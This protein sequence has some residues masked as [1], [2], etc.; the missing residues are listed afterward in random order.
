M[1]TFYLLRHAKSS[2]DEPGLADF[3]RPLNKRGRSAA[4]RM[5]VLMAE[6]GLM[7]E[8]ILCSTALRAR[9]TVE[10]IVPASSYSGPIEFTDEL[11]LAPADVYLDLLT[12]I[13]DAFS[14]VMMVGHNPGISNALLHLTGSGKHFP[15]AAL[16][17]I[18]LPITAWREFDESVQGELAEFWR[19]KE[20]DELSS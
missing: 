1:K 3:D 2:W 17:K 16:A 18:S 4:P 6:R 12:E 20:L 7:P 10:H 19:P 13:D 15:T 11:Y 5:G 8:V 9:Q 14:A